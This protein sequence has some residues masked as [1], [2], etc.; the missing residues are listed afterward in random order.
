MYEETKRRLGKPSNMIAFEFWSKGT[1][2]S[3]LFFN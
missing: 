3:L 1:I 2:Y